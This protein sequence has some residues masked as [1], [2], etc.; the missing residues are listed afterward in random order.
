MITPAMA[1]AAT[2]PTL[3][4]QPVSALSATSC[5]VVR[6]IAGDQH[7]PR[8]VSVD[9]RAADRRGQ[10][11]RHEE[12]ERHESRGG[13]AAVGVREDENRDPWAELGQAI[14]RERRPCPS[15]DRIADERSNR[16]YLDGQPYAIP[17]GELTRH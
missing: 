15:Q 2:S 5:S 9:D 13:G 3:R 4:I 17:T 1:G 7:A 11:C 10:G 14:Q 8:A 12:P 16:R 6:A